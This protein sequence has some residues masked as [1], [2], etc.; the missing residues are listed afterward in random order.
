M[1]DIQLISENWKYM[2]IVLKICHL[3]IVRQK[4]CYDDVNFWT[5]LIKLILA[6][7][8]LSNW[9]WNSALFRHYY[10]SSP[11]EKKLSISL[12]DAFKILNSHCDVENVSFFCTLNSF[13][14][15]DNLLPVAT[16]SGE[17]FNIQL[18]VGVVSHCSSLSFGSLNLS[19]FSDDRQKKN[20][21]EYLQFIVVQLSSETER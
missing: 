4:S 13:A 14:S 1:V 20:K 7:S 19:Y 12:A 5:F 15:K 6:C 3:F 17:S 11:M 16:T 10:S 8:M 18:S 2:R 21:K 9:S